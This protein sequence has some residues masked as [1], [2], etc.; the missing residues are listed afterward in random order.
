MKTKRYFIICIIIA[1]L[2][3]GGAVYLLFV[4]PGSG[5][6]ISSSVCKIKEITFYYLEGCEWCNKVKGEDTIAKIEDMG[7]KINKINAAVGPIRYKFQG[8]PTFVI[9]GK[10]YEGYRTFEEIKGL[11]DCPAQESGR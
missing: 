5:E 4:K 1:A 7:V 9:D 2:V 6:Q 8:V 3:I 11:L 10:V